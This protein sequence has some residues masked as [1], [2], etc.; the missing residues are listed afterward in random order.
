LK[1]VAGIARTSI[2]KA[3]GAHVVFP[4]A[5]LMMASGIGAAALAAHA[6]AGPEIGVAASLLLANGP[7]LAASGLAVALSLVSSRIGLL[8][9]IIAFLGTILFAA[10]MAHR[11]FGHGAL[12]TD[13][14]PIGGSLDILGWVVV[15]VAGAVGRRLSPSDP[16]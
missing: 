9:C 4:V 11:G 8:G 10:D 12:F 15:A 3:I 1:P 14:A 5:S 16:A 2:A 7:M 13:A 6:G